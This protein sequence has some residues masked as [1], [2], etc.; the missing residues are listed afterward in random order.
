MFR[1]GFEERMKDHM[2]APAKGAAADPSIR[3]ALDRTISDAGNDWKAFISRVKAHPLSPMDGAVVAVVWVGRRTGFDPAG[4]ALSK[5]MENSYH[6]FRNAILASSR[7]DRFV[8]ITNVMKEEGLVD[9][10]ADPLDP[11]PFKA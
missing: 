10:R 5:A 9:K 7:Y 11:N 3:E 2:L 1:R 8:A 6:D 4:V